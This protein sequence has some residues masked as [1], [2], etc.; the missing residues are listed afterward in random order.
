MITPRL[1]HGVVAVFIALV[2]TTAYATLPEWKKLLLQGTV[3][4]E[5][6][7]D[8]F[9]IRGDSD[10]FCA[11]IDESRPL[12][13]QTSAGDC[14]GRE[15]SVFV[16]PHK[17]TGFIASGAVL[18]LGTGTFTP[19]GVW[20]ASTAIEDWI[21]Q[22]YA[23]NWFPA[24]H[25]PRLDLYTSPIENGCAPR[26]VAGVVHRNTVGCL[27]Q[28][29]KTKMDWAAPARK[30]WKGE[31]SRIDAGER[32]KYPQ[33]VSSAFG[34]K[35]TSYK[36]WKVL[37]TVSGCFNS[38][39]VV[40]DLGEC[41]NLVKRSEVAQMVLTLADLETE[42]ASN[43]KTTDNGGFNVARVKYY[44]EQLDPIINPVAKQ[45]EPERR[46]A[47]LSKLKLAMRNHL[48]LTVEYASVASS[49]DGVEAAL[50]SIKRSSAFLNK[51]LVALDEEP[52]VMSQNKLQQLEARRERL[53][54][55]EAA[56]RAR[57][58]ALEAKA[59]GKDEVKA[60]CELAAMLS[61]LTLSISCC[62]SACKDAWECSASGASSNA[63]GPYLFQRGCYR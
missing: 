38:E 31:L 18:A 45:I 25:S 23:K 44:F 13:S 37:A 60:F 42:L 29:G 5:D 12:A 1:S 54:E 59:A 9:L 49:S 47:L 39:G 36:T 3:S 35:D 4:V 2:C 22:N 62:K 20:I 26:V 27:S 14:E 48:K 7:K 50:I 34:S 8:G 17:G 57:Q 52:T 32:P 10:P 61:D 43:F 21:Y 41:P 28:H 58:A 16:K 63:T 33:P 6:T 51:I 19:D 53:K 55:A 24:T 15:V 56:E 30:V 40:T 11:L 46:D